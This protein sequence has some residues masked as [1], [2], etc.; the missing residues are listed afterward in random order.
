MLR[1]L[2]SPQ[3]QASHLSLGGA[4]VY[5]CDKQPRILGKALAIAGS[6]WRNN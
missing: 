6:Q 4:A 1:A 2:D 5:R 3:L